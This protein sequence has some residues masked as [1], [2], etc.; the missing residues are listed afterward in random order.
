[1]EPDDKPKS[2]KPLTR[3]VA[4]PVAF[5]WLGFLLMTPF[6]LADERFGLGGLVFGLLIGLVV[7]INDPKWVVKPLRE[8]SEL[9]R[10]APEKPSLAKSFLLTGMASMVA[11][12][13]VYALQSGAADKGLLFFVA[14]F[15]MISFIRRTLRKAWGFYGAIAGMISS[16]GLLVLL[17]KSSSEDNENK[18]LVT[19]AVAVPFILLEA[20]EEV[21]A[22]KRQGA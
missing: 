21:R 3:W 17:I 2:L 4:V 22:M 10:P 7:A 11:I 8:P 15:F 18:Q 1:M 19:W 14:A 16:G 6:A 20:W 9:V 12:I 13:V 5:S